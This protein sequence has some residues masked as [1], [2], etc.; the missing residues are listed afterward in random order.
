MS[1]SHVSGDLEEPDPINNTMAE[2]E[3]EIESKDLAPIVE[4][5]LCR[6]KYK[7]R[8]D[9]IFKRYF[10]CFD[11]EDI[12]MV[13]KTRQNG[14]RKLKSELDLVRILKKLRHFSIAFRYLLTERQRFLLK[15][16]DG[17]VIDSNTDLVSVNSGDTLF[18]NTSD[19]DLKNTS[20]KQKVMIK[21]LDDVD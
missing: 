3:K 14:E 12:E 10:T 7:F 21:L 17:N 8:L 13:K 19:E 15:F 9:S 2:I 1:K 16:N 18:S 5:V 4:E 20:V 6:E 11:D